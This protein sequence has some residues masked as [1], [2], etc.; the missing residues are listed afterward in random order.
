[1]KLQRDITLLSSA[2]VILGAARARPAAAIV[3]S[4]VCACTELAT[5]VADQSVLFVGDGSTVSK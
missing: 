3:R 4:R 5:G 2:N 1:M